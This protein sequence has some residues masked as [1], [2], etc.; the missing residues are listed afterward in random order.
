MCV[1][2]VDSFRFSALPEVVRPFL[3]GSA[4]S[5]LFLMTLQLHTFSCVCHGE[6]VFPPVLHGCEIWKVSSSSLFY[7]LTMTIRF[8]GVFI[9]P[10]VTIWN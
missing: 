6:D 9:C 4:C 3:A 5:A 2:C 8:W 10:E 1:L 7:V